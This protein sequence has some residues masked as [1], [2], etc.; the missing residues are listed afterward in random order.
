GW[1]GL[2]RRD[3]VP[4]QIDETDISVSTA[5]LSRLVQARVH[6]SPGSDGHETGTVDRLTIFPPGRIFSGRAGGLAAPLCRS[7][8]VGRAARRL[9]PPTRHAGLIP[10]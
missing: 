6:P 2:P 8:R 3:P 9:G 7:A 1:G 4:R 5:R 10:G